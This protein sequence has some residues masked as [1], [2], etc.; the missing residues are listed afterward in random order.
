M[1]DDPP[2]RADLAARLAALEERVA[3]L[4][5]GE[6]P[7]PSPLSPD[8]D[9]FW[10]LAALAERAPDGAV[11][12]AGHVPLPGGERYGWQMA[13]PT[14][15]L[16]ARGWGDAAAPLAALGHPLRL[17]LLRRVLRG[18]HA[19]ADLQAAPELA[20]SGKLYHHL[21]ELTA[22]GWLAAQGRGRYA[23]PGARVVPLLAILAAAGLAPDPPPTFGTP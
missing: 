12:Y 17:E 6:A 1:P 5:G 4:E 11:L 18:E 20:G 22:T 15:A 14:P 16:L 19:V 10:A 9:A 2:A 8:P 23:V 3:R 7:P 21:R 13:A